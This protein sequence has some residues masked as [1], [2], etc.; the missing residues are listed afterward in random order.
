MGNAYPAPRKYNQCLN[1]S[2]A[3]NNQDAGWNVDGDAE[4]ASALAENARLRALVVELSN[5][6]L[7]NVVDQK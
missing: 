7:R 3:H 1:S 5:L 2:A 6:V 4:L